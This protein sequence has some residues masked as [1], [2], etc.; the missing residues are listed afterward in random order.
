MNKKCN[1]EDT[2][3][4]NYPRL[5]IIGAGNMASCIVGG[6]VNS[7][8]HNYFSDNITVSDPKNKKLSSLQQQFGI[9]INTNN[10]KACKEADIVILAVKPQVIKMVVAEIKPVLTH[11]PLV[12]SVAAGITSR[13]LTKWLGKDIP[14]VRAMPNTPA[15]V[16]NGA[17]GLYANTVVSRRQREQAES[18]LSAIGYT[19]WVEEES[20]MDTVTAVSGSGPAYF[21]L[22]M[23]AMIDAGVKQGLTK[24]IAKQLTLQTALGAAALAKSSDVDVAELRRRVT[25]PGGT[26]EQAIQYFQQANFA[27]IVTDAM[28]ACAERSRQ[29]AKAFD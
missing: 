6:L 16:R 13:Q 21:F 19:T 9:T 28:D 20:L 29:L 24:S 26:T 2:K 15:L 22:L 11:R 14:V 27:Q 1:Q 25:S 8:D 17:T 5:A 7:N 23:E 3:G 10:S 4:N 12:I 18:I